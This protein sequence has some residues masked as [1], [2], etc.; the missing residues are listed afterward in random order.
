MMMKRMMIL[1]LSVALAA[2]AL[3]LPPLSENAY[4]NDRLIQA[5][6]ADRIRKEC[7]AISAR[8]AYA[9]SQA[10]ALKRYALEQGYSDAEIEAFLDSRNDKDRVKAAAEA[11]LAANGVV[12]GDEAS[13]CA[14][15]LK[16]IAAGSVAG[17]LIYER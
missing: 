2:P 5:R 13:F 10:R 7:D 14:L 6:V 12:A 8:F 1:A 9:Y 17:S 4:I 15:G 16:E 11:Y 3:A